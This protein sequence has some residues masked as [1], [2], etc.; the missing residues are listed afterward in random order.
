MSAPFDVHLVYDTIH[1][2]YCP[3]ELIFVDIHDDYFT[4]TFFTLLQV[5]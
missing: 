4:F 1:A 2:T 3:I 5:P